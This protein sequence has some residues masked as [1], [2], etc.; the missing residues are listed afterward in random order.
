[1]EVLSAPTESSILTELT[2][3]SDNADAGLSL[4]VKN[5]QGIDT[6][7]YLV[8]GR[9]GNETTE[10][11]KVA[12]VSGTDITLS[13]ATSFAHKKGTQVQ[14]ILYNQRRFY[15]STSKIG[16][17]GFPIATKDI[18]VDRPDGTFYED[19]NGT[20]SNWYK[21][22]Y[23]NSTT[24]SETSLDDAIATKAAESEHYTSL[25]DIRKQAGFEEAYGI[26]DEDIAD[27][28]LDAENEFES[29]IATLYD[30]PLSSKPKLARQIINLLAAGMLLIKEYGMEADIEISKSG[31]RM[32]DRAYFLIDKII[33]GTLKLVDDNGNVISTKTNAFLVSGSNI[34]DPNKANTGEIFSLEDEMFHGADPETGRGA[35]H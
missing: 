28:R 8:I 14:K 26:K 27:Y 9:I 20:S 7:D 24:D 11:R 32:I 12:S 30:I 5:A 34:Y 17:W 25:D 16:P 23:Y 3:L 35:T 1:M 29:R 10:I 6:D 13:S 18:E 4:S 21:A 33:D 31:Q 19:V 15:R 2:Y 22:T